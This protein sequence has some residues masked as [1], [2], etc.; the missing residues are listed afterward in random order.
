MTRPILTRERGRG[1]LGSSGT[2]SAPVDKRVPK[3]T[4]GPVGLN[5]SFAP[6]A[7][8][9]TFGDFTGAQQRKVKAAVRLGLSAIADA[10]AALVAA[11]TQPSREVMR[12]FKITGTTDEDLAGLDLAIA[13][14]NEVAGALLGHEKLVF[15]AELTGPAF[16]LGKL[17]GHDV[18]AYVWG[19]GRPGPGEEGVVKIV[20]PKFDALS[21]EARARV[22]IHEVSH[23]YAATVDE[24]YLGGGGAGKGDSAAALRNADTYAHFALPEERGSSLRAPIPGAK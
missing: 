13:V 12:Y 2:P 3:K 17:F 8:G 7:G 20:T 15:D 22:L 11:K 6:T 18:A 10:K 23:K 16:G 4:P 21:L 1:P 9:V 24:W 5:D 14:Y 19:R